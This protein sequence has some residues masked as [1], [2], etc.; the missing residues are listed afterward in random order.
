MV[1]DKDAQRRANLRLALIL[2]SVAVV[3]ALGFVAKIWLLGPH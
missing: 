3:F 1:V 2:L